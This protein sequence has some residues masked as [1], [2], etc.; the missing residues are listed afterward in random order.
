MSTA[1]SCDGS[2]GS[3]PSRS[4]AFKR[5]ESLDPEAEFGGYDVP[6]PLGPED[7]E[8]FRHGRLPN[9]LRY[10]LRK[11]AYP[12]SRCALSLAVQAGC[13]QEEDHEQGIAHILEH[14]A[15]R[16]TQMFTNYDIVRFLE[17]IGADFG[18]DQN[19]YTSFDETV[20]EL[21]VPCDKQSRERD[22]G[23]GGEEG[24]ME[25]LSTLDKGLLVLSEFAFGV[26]ATKEE[27]NVERGTVLD[28]WRQSRT[29][30][31]RVVQAHWKA[32]MKGSKYEDR[33][34]IGIEKVIRECTA[35]EVRAFR[36]RWYAPERMAITVVGDFEESMDEM[37]NKV[38][39]MFDQQGYGKDSNPRDWPN[40]RT[41]VHE[42]PQY[43][44]QTDEEATQSSVNVS[45]VKPCEMSGTTWTLKDYRDMIVGDMFVTAINSRLF[46][47]SHS[48]ET[49]QPFYTAAFSN[50]RICSNAQCATLT[51]SCKLGG[52]LIALESLLVELARIRCHGFSIQEVEAARK[53]LLLDAETAYTERS[54]RKSDDL[55]DE[56]VGSFLLG[57]AVTDPVTEARINRLLLSD[58]TREELG[59]FANQ[60]QRSNGMVIQTVEPP[61]SLSL[62]KEDHEKLEAVVQKVIGME[63][64]EIKPH[65]DD[66]SRM[67]PDDILRE[68]DIGHAKPSFEH[69]VRSYP[70]LN[71]KEVTLS[72]GMRLC[73]KRSSLREDQLL[74][75]AFAR[76]GLSQAIRGVT[77]DP[78]EE[79]VRRMR[80]ANVSS[81]FA[82][83]IGAFG[84]RPPVLNE[85]LAGLRCHVGTRVRPFAR[86]FE[87]EQS[88]GDFE[89][90]LKLIHRLFSTRVQAVDSELG[91][92]KQM[93]REAIQ[94]QIRDPMT[95]YSQRVKS[96]NYNSFYF[97]PW[98]LPE[99]DA[100]D[101]KESCEFYSECFNHPGEFTLIVVGDIDEIAETDEGFL[102][103]MEKYV[104]SIEVKDPARNVPLDK[105]EVVPIPFMQPKETVREI[106]REKLVDPMSITQVTFPLTITT[107]PVEVA[108]EELFWIS[109]M[110]QLLEMQLMKEM[111][112]QRGEV[113]SVSVGPS[114]AIES[115][116]AIPSGKAR[117]DVA[118]NFSCEPGGVAEKLVN[119]AV[120][121]VQRLRTHPVTKSDIDS[122]LE[123]E[124]RSYEL[125]VEENNFWLEVIEMAY[126]SRKYK[127][128]RS[129]DEAYMFRKKIREAVLADINP[130]TMAVAFSK[131]FADTEKRVYTAITLEPQDSSPSMITRLLASISDCLST[132]KVSTSTQQVVAGA[133]LAVGLGAAFAYLSS[134]RRHG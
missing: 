43:M 81:L 13:V 3:E 117:G 47:R 63:K 25:S 102:Q 89:V 21:F 50:D 84:F 68:G 60:Y 133:V 95:K 106:V 62:G 91:N 125:A 42:E 114:F 101:A 4:R 65:K 12:K 29:S 71:A 116:S 100:I 52:T 134:S 75:H 48:K 109:F 107:M 97:R 90:T 82:S 18:A 5:L 39:T 105:S 86:V 96:V 112:F 24:S 9:G 129:I 59:A 14:L 88:S 104:G 66:E 1:G 46:R 55:R 70:K 94:N 11:N 113:Y 22:R 6:L 115:P 34:P 64:G 73:W 8:K 61:H 7:R 31:S 15:F 119:L 110:C 78:S 20:Y 80:T 10:Y 99:F 111:R 126:Q 118:I 35:E 49:S 37:E 58:I 79:E 130:E 41:K 85:A 124:K 69:E 36:D 128:T 121:E 87:G 123:M 56:Y 54:K 76:G 74:I 27:L 132:K 92:I 26:T 67:S 127:Q 57:E 17:S 131:F 103:L 33:L 23:G 28:E 98:T 16:G 2:P 120:D 44:C 45:F 108:Q 122:L 77:S 51:A 38:A 40:Y 72:N 83:D 93:V 32:I 19:A 30:Q 53:E